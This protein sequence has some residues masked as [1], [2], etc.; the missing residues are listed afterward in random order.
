MTAVI[1]TRNDPARNMHR[2][3]RLDVQRDLFGTWCFISGWGRIGQAGQ[4][5]SIPYP[6]PHDAG[7][8]LD[9]QRRGKERRGYAAN[10][11]ERH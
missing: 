3:Y 7:A 9:R 1:L 11:A 5:R 6:T 10:S 2:Y 8:P 4:I